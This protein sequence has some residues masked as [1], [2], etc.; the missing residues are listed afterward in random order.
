MIQQLSLIFSPYND[1]TIVTNI[2]PIQWY[3]NCHL[4]SPH[5]TSVTYILPIQWYKNCHL[6][7]PH[8]IIQ[9]LSLI[10]SPYNDTTIVTYILLMQRYNNCHLHSPHTTIQ[11][12]SLTFSLYNDTT[13]VTYILPIQ[14]Y[15]N[16]HLY[17]PHTT[18]NQLSLI[19]PLTQPNNLQL[20][21]FI[22]DSYIRQPN[23]TILHPVPFDS[24]S[25]SL[26]VSSVLFSSI[27]HY[28]AFTHIPILW[29]CT[30]PLLLSKGLA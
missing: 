15:N 14:W 9:Q 18:I 22:L 5:T 28:T 29:C 20:P 2:L 19:F 17:S 3:N 7:S 8:T 30:I 26:I 1:T 4:Y 25:K 11:Q 6:Y 27:P 16:C 10:F 21:I 24:L 12:L 13:I 23:I